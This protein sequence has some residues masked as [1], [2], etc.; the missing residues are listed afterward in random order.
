[1]APTTSSEVLTDTG[2]A[3][4]FC[5]PP[6]SLLNM[7]IKFGLRERATRLKNG[8]QQV[9]LNYFEKSVVNPLVS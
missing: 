8:R 4:L 7:V 2:A 6:K 5:T 1:M 9:D 3:G